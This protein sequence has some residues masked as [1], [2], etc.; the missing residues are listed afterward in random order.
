MWI[1]RQG[2]KQPEP[3]TVAQEGRVTL[4]G[5][6]AAVYLDGERRELPIFG[7][8]GY[9]WR[10]EQDEQ[11]LVLKMGSAGEEQCIFAQRCG[12]ESDLKQGEI[13][14]RTRNTAIH[15]HNN[16]IIDLTGIVR[17]NGKL[18]MTME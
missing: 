9:V 17:V 11:V 18:V 14:I 7:P 5:D 1:A 4:G 2:M 3:Q 10:P 15:L 8:G 12:E 13:L 16:G 6:P